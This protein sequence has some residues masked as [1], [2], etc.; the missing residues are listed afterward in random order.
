MDRAR[1]DWILKAIEWE[2]LTSWEE[3]FLQ[4]CDSQLKKKNKLSERQE[5]II[6]RIF[7]EKQ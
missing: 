3:D 5:E 1:F 7:R 2:K 4:S 6:E